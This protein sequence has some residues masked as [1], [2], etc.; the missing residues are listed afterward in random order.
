MKINIFTFA[1]LFSSLT[2]FAQVNELENFRKELTAFVNY[3]N[4]KT[5]SLPRSFATAQKLRKNMEDAFLAFVLHKDSKDLETLKKAAAHGGSS[6]T[7]DKYSYFFS[8]GRRD[9]YNKSK[10]NNINYQI[11]FYGLYDYKLPNFVSM[12]I[13]PFRVGTKDYVI[14][15]YK[16]S[17]EGKYYIKDA[18]TNKVIFSKEALTSDAAILKFEKID[19]KHSLLLEDMGYNGQRALVVNTESKPWKMLNAFSGRSLGDAPADY[20][21]KYRPGNHPYLR[22]AENKSIVSMYGENFLK[23]YEI[24]F[25]GATKTISYKQYDKDEKNVKTIQAKWEY[26]LFKIDDYYIGLDLNGGDVPYPY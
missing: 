15:Y 5:D 16:L 10:E 25:D 4:G 3:D 21:L 8:E 1:L 22:F 13:Q 19:D 20:S 11:T 9:M 23:K 18:E 6:Y 7:F 24:N 12:Y 2:S 26:N 14:Y 17:G